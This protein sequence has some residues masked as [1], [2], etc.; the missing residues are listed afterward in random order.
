MSDEKNSSHSGDPTPASGRPVWLQIVLG[1]IMAVVGLIAVGLLIGFLLPSNFVVSRAIVIN[2]PAAEIH[3]YVDTLGQW[4]SWT[5]WN[6]ESYPELKY[7]Y[8]GPESGVGAVQTWTDPGMGG[9]RLEITDSSEEKGIQFVL[10]FEQSPEPLTGSITYAPID[11]GG[12]KVTWTGRGD[13]GS[14]PI[15]R[16][17]GLMMDSMIGADYETGLKKL[18][19]LVEAPPAE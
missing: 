9:G 2:A 13:V 11:G 5:A 10:Q 12:T 17:F 14:N 1:S 7:S 19:V 4:P 6:N 18:K 8:E 15:G 16:Y 3:P